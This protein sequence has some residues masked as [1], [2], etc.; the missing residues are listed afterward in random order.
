MLLKN[1]VAFVTGSAQ[2]I[3]AAIARELA[4]AGADIVI[5]DINMEPAQKTADEIKA[6]GV[7]TMAIKTNVTD[8]SDVENSVKEIAGKMGKISI[9]VNNAGITKDGLLLRMKPEDWAAVIAV[10]LTGVFNCTKAVLPLMIKAKEG[11]IINIAS[12]VGEMG[13]FGQANYAASKGGVIA[14]TKSVA[15]ES[16]SR[17]ICCNAIAPGFIRTAM[18]DKIPENVKEQM[19]AQIPMKKLGEPKDIADA[20]VFLASVAADY[21]TGQVIN[22]NGG[23]LMNT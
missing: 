14:F 9:L 13:N 5:S 22:V 19:L 18:T 8:L 23:M 21:I 3:G 16:A 7:K 12:I 10:N 1:K 17:G 6:L 4:L 2:G 15:K 20:V 11:K